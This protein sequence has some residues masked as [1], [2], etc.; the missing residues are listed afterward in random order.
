M[1]RSV[2][3]VLALVASASAVS[4]IGVLSQ[5]DQSRLGKVFSSGLAS[6]DVASIHYSAAGLGLL[7]A[8]IPNSQNACAQVKKGLNA[9]SAES[10][11]HAASAAKA[12]GNCKLD[13]ANADSVLSIADGTDSQPIYYAIAARKALG[14]PVDA[15]AAAKSLV[16]VVQGSKV[17]IASHGYA[18]LAA[19]ILG[20]S[21]AL[22]PVVETIEDVVNFADEY[23]G[24]VLQFL[25][26][27]QDGLPVT[28][29]I[30]NGMFALSSGAPAGVKADQVIMLANYFLRSRFTASAADAYHVLMSLKTIAGGKYSPITMSLVGSSS[31]SAAK[32][33][34]K[35]RATNLLDAAVKGV[36][37][38]L[39]AA[40]QQ[41][42][43][44]L[45]S[46]SKLKADK[47][48]EFSADLSGKNAPRGAYSFK[49]TASSSDKQFVELEEFSV[50]VNLVDPVK[51]TSAEFVILDADQDVKAKTVSLSYPKTSSDKLSADQHQRLALSF[52][53]QDSQGEAVVL[54]QMFV[55]MTHRATG[56]EI[57]FVAESDEDRYK[58]EVNLG[59]A[60]KESFNSNSGD[61]D[62]TLIAGDG[63]VT[64]SVSWKFG[65]ISLS[66]PGTPATGKAKLQYGA[67]PEIQHKFREPEKRPAA[68]ISNAFTLAVLS[69]ILLLLV[70]WM[71]V[72]VNLNDFNKGGL[73]G[74]LFLAGLIAIM[75]IYAYFWL[76]SNMFSTIKLLTLVGIPTFIF[77]NRLLAG[78]AAQS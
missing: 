8:S 56:Q 57:F 35:V 31:V 36:S 3:A 16:S 73:N 25:H 53:A 45:V 20:K 72:G 34:V 46:D 14:L 74:I 1:W 7:G 52:N 10:V 54:H 66:F 39:V 4:P 64:E 65:S 68:V 17:S 24:N 18:L 51:I 71:R 12:L 77:G 44:E 69:P 27:D 6:S 75:L 76:A 40:G 15:A 43:E 5:A 26:Y 62:M 9:Q 29:A 55:Q 49:F 28:A 58:C 48:G 63:L 78:M 38:T 50:D 60:A 37:V 33:V 13:I 32:P 41:D 59:S 47:N 61:Y 19:S 2:L 30:V 11:Y 70:A 21:D 67:R 23:G 22:K 42:E